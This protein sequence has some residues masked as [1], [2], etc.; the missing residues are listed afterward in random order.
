M[1]R[2]DLKGRAGQA[3]WKNSQGNS[4]IRHRFTLICHDFLIKVNY[5]CNS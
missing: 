2:R 1:A 5:R 4:L 3:G